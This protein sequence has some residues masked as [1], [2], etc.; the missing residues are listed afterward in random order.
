M[1]V[2]TIVCVGVHVGLVAAVC[3]CSGCNIVILVSSPRSSWPFVLP[4]SWGLATALRIRP[5]EG[6]TKLPDLRALVGRVD[7]S[8]SDSKPELGEGRL[9]NPRASSNFVS[10]SSLSSCPATCVVGS[11]RESW[12]ERPPLSA[13]CVQLVEKLSATL[14]QYTWHRASWLFGDSPL[15][16]LA[17]V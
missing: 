13:L 5:S 2:L 11:A 3:P 1:L 4:G 6:N 8:L 17:S 14:S 7:A 12:W 16:D 9:K 15:V 10:S